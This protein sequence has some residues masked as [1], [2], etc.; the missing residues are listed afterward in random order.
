MTRKTGLKNS[1]K[2]RNKNTDPQFLEI[3]GR[4]RPLRYR[5]LK[6]REL[7]EQRHIGRDHH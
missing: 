5:S 4:V 6:G 1:D 7:K 2:Y 3:E